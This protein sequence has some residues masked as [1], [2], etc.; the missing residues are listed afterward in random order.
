MRIVHVQLHGVKQILHPRRLRDRTVD[1]VLIL[2]ANDDL[3]GHRDLI[4]VFVADGRARLLR[5][6]ERNRDGRFRNPSLALFVYEFLQ[7]GTS[8]LEF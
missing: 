7:R 4:A 5:V 6:V 3:T 2:P 1:H 8:Y